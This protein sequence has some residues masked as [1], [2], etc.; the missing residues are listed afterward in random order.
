MANTTEAELRKKNKTLT[1]LGSYP[2]ENV[3]LTTT[4]ARISEVFR[5][6]EFAPGYGSALGMVGGVKLAVG[7]FVIWNSAGSNYRCRDRYYP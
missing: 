5:G 3:A 2:S 4:C 6:G 7:S 1:I